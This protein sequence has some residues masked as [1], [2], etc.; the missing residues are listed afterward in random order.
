MRCHIDLIDL[1]II[2]SD[3]VISYRT[4]E[5]LHAYTTEICLVELLDT[6]SPVSCLLTDLDVIN[7]CLNRGKFPNAR[8]WQ[9]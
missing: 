9:P 8:A 3:V 6:A 5:V 1:A 7:Y 4:S 2:V